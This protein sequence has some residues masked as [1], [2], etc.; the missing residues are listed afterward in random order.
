MKPR[1]I[2]IQ[3]YRGIRPQSRLGG[4]RSRE[5]KRRDRDEKTL[6]KTSLVI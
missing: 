2:A 1:I 3:P 4:N 5:K 6:F